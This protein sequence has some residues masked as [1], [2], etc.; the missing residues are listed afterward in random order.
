M[1]F[2]RDNRKREEGMIIRKKREIWREKKG[3]KDFK[4]FILFE[5]IRGNYANRDEKFFF[6]R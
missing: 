5:R 6:S 2:A 4:I 3:K 1:Y